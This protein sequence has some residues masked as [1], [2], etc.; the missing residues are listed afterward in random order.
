MEEIIKKIIEEKMQ[1]EIKSKIEVETKKFYRELTERK[2]QYISEIMNG[3]RIYHERD[4]M[5]LGMN[6]TIIFKNV[7]RLEK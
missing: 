2:D 1:E 7:V 3:I 4:E 6:Y 5:N